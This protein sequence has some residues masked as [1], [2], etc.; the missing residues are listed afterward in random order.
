MRVASPMELSWLEDFL[1]LA[2]TGNFSRAAEIRHITQPAFSRRI[3]ALEDWI[4]TSLFDRA[5]HHVT[6]TEAGRQ[7]W[8]TAGEAVR[9]IHQGRD[10]ARDAGSAEATTLRFAATHVLSFTFFPEWLR[11]L[12][13]STEVGSIRLISDSMQACEQVLTQGQAQFLLCHHHQAAPNRLDPSRYHSIVIGHDLIVPA[14]QPT[15]GHVADALAEVPYLAYSAESGLGRIIAATRGVLPGQQPVFT[16]HL[17]AVL[18]TMASDGRGIAWLP[19]SLIKSDLERGILTRI[20]PAEWPIPIDIRL[21]RPRARQSLAAE[22]FWKR[23]EEQRGP[24]KR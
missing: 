16:S 7:F 4:G 13:A 1:T 6:L 22:M 9:L 11:S 12:E 3:R 5:T 2:E 8:P 14:M 18:R 15:E 23:L 10:S 17:A 21:F 20:G 24:A 19:L